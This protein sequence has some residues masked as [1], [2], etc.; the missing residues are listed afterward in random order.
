[1]KKIL[2]ALKASPIA[3]VVAGL[4]VAGVASAA[5]LSV[6]TTMLGTGNVE[7]SVKFG[8]GDIEKTYTIGD[9][10][11]I[12]GNT[13][14]QD[15]NLKN[16]SDT[17]APIKF[18]TNQ[19][20]VGG[21]HCNDTSHDEEGVETTYWSTVKLENKDSSDWSIKDSDDMEGTLTYN[22]VSNVFEYEFEAQGLEHEDDYSLVYY[23]DRQDRF[24]DY[25]GDNPGALIAEFTTDD[26][27]SISEEG[28]KNLGMDLP[29]PDDW[30]GT[31]DADYC[32]NN[33]GD[34]YELCRGAKIWLVPSD[35]Y[36]EVLNKVRDAS[37]G[38]MSKFLFETDLIT[39]DDINNGE[40]LYLGTG[41]LNFFAKTVFDVATQPGTYK[42]NTEVQPVQ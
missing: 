29:H 7:Q 39:Y 1:M 32:N 36:N 34:N 26:E 24:D 23:A 31:S 20:I 9:S 8:N 22:L 27:G 14:T 13:Y 25:G 10:P 16:S 33:E 35:D 5:L 41:Q 15:Y 18:V 37:W 11:A 38:N 3:M 2:K 19:C 28:T 17:T 42:V 40:A 4:L 21:G 6:Y 12:A 30:N